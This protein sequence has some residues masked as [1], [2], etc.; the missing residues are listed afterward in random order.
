MKYE[1]PEVT[2]QTFALSAIQTAS[3]KEPTNSED[4]PGNKHLS[5]SCYEDNE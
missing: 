3:V 5:I 1:K 4:Q 2:V